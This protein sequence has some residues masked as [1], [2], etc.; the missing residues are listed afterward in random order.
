MMNPGAPFQALAL[1]A[2]LAERY[3]ERCGG[4][5]IL[6]GLVVG[7]GVVQLA[8]GPLAQTSRFSLELLILLVL[9]LVGPMLVALVALALLLPH[10]VRRVQQGERTLR[11]ERIAAAAL[12][13][14]LLQLLFLVSA[15]CGGVLATPRTDLVGE[16]RELLGGCCCSTWAGPACGRGCFWRP[17]VPGASGARALP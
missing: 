11:P 8:S 3:G 10:W 1:V 17:S 9:Q 15:V 14:P 16:F 12:V 13:G 4:P 7:L 2:T 5:L 6:A